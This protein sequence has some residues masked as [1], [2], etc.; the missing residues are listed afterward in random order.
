MASDGT[1]PPYYDPDIPI[2]L[3]DLIGFK[4]LE[5]LCKQDF[6]GFRFNDFYMICP[7]QICGDFQGKRMI[8]PATAASGIIQV[9]RI[10]RMHGI[11]PIK[12]WL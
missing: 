6:W 5:L 4:S 3:I 2:D 9:T 12:E 10:I 1:V 8:K 7:I 11:S